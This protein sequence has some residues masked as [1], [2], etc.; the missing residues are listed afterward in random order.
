DEAFY[1]NIDLR[2][3]LFKWR[4]GFLPMGVGIVGGY[5]YGRVWLEGED[6]TTWHNSQTIGIWLNI[7][8][9]TIIQ[10][11]YSLTEEGNIFS[12]Q[13]GFNF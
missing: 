9:M 1:H 13:M 6:S 12:L 5:D 7:L 4:N 2:L 8:K 10:P 3:F 11:Y